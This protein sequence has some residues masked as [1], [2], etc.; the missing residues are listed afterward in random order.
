MQYPAVTM[1]V[2]RF[3]KRLETDPTLAKKMKQLRA[4]LLVKA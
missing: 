3:A 4:T 2:R 1:P